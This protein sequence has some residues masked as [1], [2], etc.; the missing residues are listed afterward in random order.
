[1]NT[2]EPIIVFDDSVK[3]KLINSLGLQ[4][5]KDGFLEDSNGKIITDQD[6]DPLSIKDFGGILKGSKLA[7][8]NDIVELAKYFISS[9]K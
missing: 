1:M 4:E 8:K 2:K 5:N 3:D 9:D 6:F 7:I